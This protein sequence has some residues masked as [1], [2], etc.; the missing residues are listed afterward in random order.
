M[1]KRNRRLISLCLSAVMLSSTCGSVYAAYD[2]D[3]DVLDSVGIS[4]VEKDGAADY[5][6]YHSL[7]QE[8]AEQVG[9]EGT[10]LL[11]NENSTL[12]LQGDEDGNIYV[13]VF[14]IKGYS[15]PRANMGFGGPAPEPTASGAEATASGGNATVAQAETQQ[16]ETEPEPI[17]I[18]TLFGS[19]NIISSSE[20][21]ESTTGKII[22]NAELLNAYDEWSKTYADYMN[23]SSYTA[24][25]EAGDNDLVKSNATQNDWN[26]LND[27]YDADGNLLSK[28]MSEEAKEQAEAFSENAIVVLN[29]SSGE[30]TDLEEGEQRISEN[31]VAML[32]YVTNHY[33]NVVIVLLTPNMMEAG[34]VDG[35][36]YTYSYYGYGGTS[37]SHNAGRISAGEA[38][39]ILAYE[40]DRTYHIEPADACLMIPATSSTNLDEAFYNIL[41]GEVSPSGR[42]ADTMAYDF[43]ENPVSANVGH[44]EF[45]DYNAEYSINGND[46]L[47]ADMGDS[48]YYDQ[49]YYYLV[50]EEGIYSGYRYYE[51]F[52]HYGVQYPFGYGLS[53]TSFDWDI[54][55]YYTSY[56]EYGEL[57]FNIDVTVTNTGDVAG[58]DVVELYYTQPYY[59]DGSYNV[60]KSIVNLGA[61]EKTSLLEPGASETVTLTWA[62]RDMAS[63]SNVVENYVLEAGTYY[64]EVAKD[65]GDAWEIYYGVDE[66]A[67]DSQEYL[68]S[69]E[70]DAKTF[71]EDQDKVIDIEIDIISRASIDCSGVYETYDVSYKGDAEYLA[72]EFGTL[73]ILKDEVTGTAYQNL[74]T[75][76]VYDNGT[77]DY[78]A[79][80]LGEVTDGYLHRVDDSDGGKVEEATQITTQN[81]PQEP[82]EEEEKLNFELRGMESAYEF[83][84]VSTELLEQLNEGTELS[85]TNKTYYDQEGN[86]QN[87]MLSDVYAFT[88]NEDSPSYQNM[89][90]IKAFLENLS[91][92]TS[93]LGE[94]YTQETEDYIWSCFLDQMNVFELMT[95]F[96]C[97]GFEG[98][99][100]LQYGIPKS[101]NADGPESIGTKG[102][103]TIEITSFGPALLGTTWNRELA[104][105]Y[106]IAI[107]GEA[108][109]DASNTE[110]TV[111][112][113]APNLNAH[114]SMLGGRS[115]QNYSEDAFLSGEICAA[116]IVGCQSMGVVCVV[117][118]YSLNDAEYDREGVCTFATEQTIRELYC[119]AWEE[120]FKAGASGMMCS[121]G[122]VGTHEVCESYAMCVSLLREEWGFDGHII[123][124]GYGVTKYMYP[125]SCLINAGCG[126]LVMFNADHM[127]D[128]GDYF[129]LYEFYRE[130]PNALLYA[131]RM[132]A[133]EMCTSKME[134]GTFWYYYSD[135]SYED[136]LAA[137]NEENR[138][139]NDDYGEA[140]WY[141]TS[142]AVGYEVKEGEFVYT[143]V[144][145]ETSR[146][147]IAAME[148]YGLEYALEENGYQAG[149]EISVPVSILDS[150]GLKKFG[151]SVLFDTEAFEFEGVDFQDSIISDYAYNVTETED[152]ISVTFETED[153]IFKEESGLLF[154]L[155]LKVKEDTQAGDY[156]ISIGTIEGTNFEGK[157]CIYTTTYSVGLGET[158]WDVSGW[159]G[160][161][162]PDTYASNW[163]EFFGSLGGSEDPNITLVASYISIAE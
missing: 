81:Y 138:Y 6:Y 108:V 147:D 77:Y 80:G 160:S 46:Y 109:S 55:E 19:E 20:A 2:V 59:A 10:V 16:E 158:D 98:P 73:H 70:M 99:G 11:K 150:E 34:F 159:E 135:Y 48:D 60:E 38:G 50:Y 53:Y 149:D 101:Y 116:Q 107:S 67:E 49:G 29:R 31:E 36:D 75:G 156:G 83:D 123:T 92:D 88:F 1:K 154:N 151:F 84:G 115:S 37:R 131:L 137:Q 103:N 28:A 79:Q 3:T 21:D 41:T 42:L 128:K 64:F 17:T 141:R 7:A 9:E 51:T 35:G 106:G 30:G 114:R 39:T 22:Y 27:I 122:R 58:K 130:Y 121:L 62:A 155:K 125:I 120:V 144:T 52:D 56:D 127:S 15:T 78:D 45:D 68:Q 113:Y 69:W 13:N 126:L 18:G 143:G 161:A 71:P 5:E 112:W 89:T 61:F 110:A 85:E 129:E 139:G 63:Y 142:I 33:E 66:H 100:F 76:D 54:G 145:N 47:E 94:E 134:T 105:Q 162:Y 146:Q 4:Y 136:Y 32:D 95:L 57:N 26:L 65:A 152:G 23:D 102:E 91:I 111:M 86:V 87:I 90:E 72:D 117:K 96:Y 148:G 25:G 43:Q 163:D 153:Q 124:D 104:T 133:R 74:F 24:S 82:G 12:P 132:Y 157:N 97:S 40:E 140:M 14:G 8:L 118:H 93:S 119:G 44:F